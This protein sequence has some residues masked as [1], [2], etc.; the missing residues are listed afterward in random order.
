MTQSSPV[1]AGPRPGGGRV[2]AGL[3]LREGEGDERAAGRQVR[4]PALLLLVAARQQQ[5]QRAQLLDREDQPARRAC[6][7]DLLDREADRQQ[8]AAQA[9]VRLGERQ[10]QDVVGG[11][12]LLDVPRELRR[13]V[14][15]GRSRR[16]PLVGEDADRVA[17]HLLL[18]GQA[19]RPGVRE[20]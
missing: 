20:G 11:E 15:L 8:L 10:A 19:V 13:P 3:G 5:R 1:A 9:T 16:D 4:E 7:A 17:E 18:L 12:E 2:A 14:D 6:P